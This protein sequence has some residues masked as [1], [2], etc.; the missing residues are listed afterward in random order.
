MAYK[1]YKSAVDSVKEKHREY[2]EEQIKEVHDL[3][4]IE[5][6]LNDINVPENIESGISNLYIEKG[7][8]VKIYKL[9]IK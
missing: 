1:D 2:I 5:S 3:Y 6:I 8:N 4:T 9:F 7:I